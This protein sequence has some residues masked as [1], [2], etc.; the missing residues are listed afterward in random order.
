MI[1]NI[2]SLA[3]L[4]LLLNC[5][6][7]PK[8]VSEKKPAAAPEKKLEMKVSNFGKSNASLFTMTNINGMEVTVTNY[9]GIITSIKTPDK[10]GKIE[11]VALGFNTFE[12]YKND[13]AY[14]GA[15]I[16]RYANRIAGGKFSIDGKSYKLAQNNAPN[17]LHG[18]V[19]GFNKKFWVFRTIKD[20]DRVGV[21]LYRISPDGE[22]GFPGEL[23]T[24]VSY[25]LDNDNNLTIEYDAVTDKPTVINLT[26]HTYFNLKGE[27]NGD[28]LD[29]LLMIP[30][31]KYTPVDENLIPTGIESSFKTPLYFLQSTPIGERIDEYNEQL[32]FGNGY[33]HNYILGRSTKKPIIAAKVYEPTTGRY[34]EVISNQPAIQFYSGNFLDGT[35][36]K[37]GK[38]Y[39]RRGGFCLETQHYPDSPNQPN[40]PSTVIREGDKFKSITIYHFDAAEENPSKNPARY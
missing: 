35:I 1:K 21:S 34:L 15:I 27:G 13:G 14:M 5:N 24:N 10:N 31:E 20:P 25:T 16:G 38:P 22:E 19:E 3:A 8:D 9:G 2:L 33:D 23:K 28:I 17:S 26:N 7:P 4:F 32:K 12:E 18:G 36:G 40:F 29:H 11:D 37:S 30:A 6:P 39:I